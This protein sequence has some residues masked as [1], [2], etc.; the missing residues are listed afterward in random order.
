[1]SN[2]NVNYMSINC[3]KWVTIK[4]CMSSRL[5]GI[6]AYSARDLVIMVIGPSGVFTT[7]GGLWTWTCFEGLGTVSGS[8]GG[9]LLT[10]AEQLRRT[11]P[12]WVRTMYERGFECC[13]RTTPSRSWSRIHTWLPGCSSV[14]ALDRCLLSLL[15][16][17]ASD[18]IL[19]HC[20]R[21]KASNPGSSGWKPRELPRSITD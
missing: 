20:C 5:G 21:F 10:R 6:I 17:G 11:V 9:E 13:P 18:F 4:V 15:V 3:L 14:K 16:V 7:L 12:S 2:R 8:W 19:V 1:M